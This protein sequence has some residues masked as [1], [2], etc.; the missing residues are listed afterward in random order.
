MKLRLL[1]RKASSPRLSIKLNKYI[2]DAFQ[3]IIN[4][5]QRTD[6]VTLECLVFVLGRLCLIYFHQ[7]WWLSGSF[8]RF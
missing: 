3:K 2:V 6:Q 4:A 1:D 5:I 8:L 7:V